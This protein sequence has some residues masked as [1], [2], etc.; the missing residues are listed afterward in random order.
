MSDDAQREQTYSL[1]PEQ[2]AGRLQMSL[3]GQHIS[4]ICAFFLIAVENSGT[5]AGLSQNLIRRVE[6]VL[7]RF[8]RTSDIIGFLGKNRFGVL[9]SGKLAENVIWEKASMLSQVLRMDA[10]EKAIPDPQSYIGVCVFR[11]GT[12]SYDRML[13]EAEYALLMTRRAEQ[14]QY[15][16]HMLRGSLAGSLSGNNPLS[17]FVVRNYMDEGIRLLHVEKGIQPVF[18][19]PGYYQRLSLEP[20]N[21]QEIRIHPEDQPAFER[22]VRA[23]R[24]EGRPVNCRYRV[25]AGSK[26]WIPCS[27]RLLDIS[28]F[29]GDASVVLEISHDL[30]SFEKLRRQLEEDREWMQFLLKKTDN[31]LWEVDL[32]TRQYR[33]LYT[34]NFL[35]GRQ[36]VYENFPESLIESGRIH[37]DSAERF[38][39]FVQGM[40]EGRQEDSG[41]FMM[42]YRQT[43]CFGWASLSYH[44]LYDEQGHPAKAIGIKEELSYQPRQQGQFVQR[45]IMPANLYPHL[46]CFLQ[47]DLNTD[48][49]E[50]LQLEG[51]EQIQLIRYQRY[52]ELMGEGIQKLF[53]QGD[54]ERVQREFQRE[55]LLKAFQEGRKWIQARYR[56]TDQ[57]GII[58]WV[59][60]GVNLVQDHETG[61]VCL[62]AYMSNLGQRCRWE[63][64]V[65]KEIQRDP[66]TGIY[67][68][69]TP[70]RMAAYLLQKNAGSLHA[71]AVIQVEG[72]TELFRGETPEQSRKQSELMSALAFSLDTDCI[73]GRCRR[74]LTVFFP[75]V[76][77]ETGLRR[78]I[79][80]AFSFVRLALTDMEEMKYLRLV[81]GVVCRTTENAEY[82]QML[83]E[84]EHL[85]AVHTSEAV[86]A[87][88]FSAD[89]GDSMDQAMGEV[90]NSGELDSFQIR[91]IEMAHLLTEEEK[92]LALDCMEAM[93]QAHSGNE[94]VNQVLQK[95]GLYYQADR[96]CTLALSENEQVVTMLNE[97]VRK[98]KHKIQQVISG[99]RL[100]E[101]PL[102]LR[103]VR[104]TS[105][106]I[107]SRKTAG[108]SQQEETAAWQ[109]GIFP[110]EAAA[111]ARAGRNRQVLFMEGVRCHGE[112]TALL[113]KLIPYLKGERERFLPSYDQAAETAG[114][115][116]TVPN[117]GSYMDVVYSLDSDLYSS[118]GALTVEVQDLP[119]LKEQKGYEYGNRLTLR[120]SE[121]L[122]DV[123][124][125]AFLFHV[126][127]GE[128]VVL[129]VN[130]TYEL[131]FERCRRVKILL[132]RQYARQYRIGHTWSDGVFNARDLVNKA[133]SIMV[134]DNAAQINESREG[135]RQNMAAQ[136]LVMT[137][138]FTIYLQ[139]KVDMRNGSLVG[140]EALV[141]V[142]DQNGNLQ[143][144]GKV[145]DQMEK[146]GTIRELDYF[147][148]DRALSVMSQWKRKGY[149][150]VPVSTNFS[151]NTLL[152]PSSLASVLAILSRYPNVP[153]G[154]VELEITETA[155]D[156]ESNTFADLID[157]FRSFGMQF[158]LDDFGSH[159]SNVSMLANIQ[160]H[161]V[162]LDRSMVRGVTENSVAR[163]MVQDM[164]KLCRRCGMLCI[165]EGVETEAQKEALLREGCYLA[166]GYYFGRP[167][168]VQEF[169]DKFLKN[170]GEGGT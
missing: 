170:K 66:E 62:F 140:A 120:I 35:Q 162:K 50:K 79:R 92:D 69:D 158:S 1:D 113:D 163:M 169:E 133:R 107:L 46:Y 166:Q 118:L 17:P 54:A 103:Y 56:I 159:Y 98:G 80:N 33:M 144:H 12:I 45:R 101:F 61:D 29:T 90:P 22:A 31:V 93:L 121:I 110:M 5:W 111:P 76:S 83:Q 59:A 40:Y 152:N 106:M 104:N 64:A 117:L 108:D 127:E 151:R 49:V 11:G 19:S 20:G 75:E 25:S 23:A 37:R 63:R 125:S 102:L 112:R 114:R 71:L 48:T 60:C 87:I 10:E 148:F 96:V 57:E 72:E 91:S 36:S 132:D 143:P 15:Y 145:I 26:N 128:F 70:R 7:A 58:R 161:S 109:Y 74:G 18:I 138:Q 21:G 28:S 52:T 13:E 85:C 68:G 51:R 89:E 53:F 8:F 115:Y 150:D 129:S 130:T 97:W 30:S 165:A 154:Q 3:A 6:N 168:P 47:V 88:V 42:Q 105:P 137:G 142:I 156:F 155:G 32:K 94:S 9:I 4:D 39:K 14:K 2:T 95:I 34:E 44:M 141:R 67:L 116:V 65:E 77:T 126:R 41:N 164:A 100:R 27:V 84:A 119:L 131:F 73:V 82:Q 134:C 55:V 38:R 147:V 99:K 157:R 123:F 139:P 24:E 160:F 135:S 81:A 43:S 16:V 167:M 153:Q 124:G 122:T 136:E 78:R 149:R 86:D 146:E